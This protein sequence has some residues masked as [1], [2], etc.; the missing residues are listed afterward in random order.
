M[1]SGIFPNKLGALPVSASSALDSAP[2]CRILQSAPHYSRA[3]PS[4]VRGKLQYRPLPSA[5][6]TFNWR[7]ATYPPTSWSTCLPF[8]S[9]SPI[10]IS[11]LRAVTGI[12]Q[13]KCAVLLMKIQNETEEKVALIQMYTQRCVSHSGLVSHA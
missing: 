13:C 5:C 1:H 7:S 2:L 4:P 9:I 8:T 10:V 6:L 12:I 11:H 3:L